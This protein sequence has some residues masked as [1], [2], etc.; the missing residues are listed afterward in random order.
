MEHSGGS[1]ISRWGGADPLGGANLRCIHFL[2]KT[3][4]KMKEMDPVGGRAPAAPPPLDPPMEHLLWNL[5]L[6]LI[7]LQ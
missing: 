4:A 6:Q 7:H 3:Y 2:A 5:H 1:R